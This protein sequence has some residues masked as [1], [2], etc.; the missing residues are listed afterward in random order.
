[1]GHACFVLHTQGV[2]LAT[3]PFAPSLGWSLPTLEMRIVTSSHDHP[4]HRWLQACPGAKA[5]VGPGEYEVAGVY[6]RG[7]KT[8]LSKKAGP[9]GRNTVF[10]IEVEG[11][12][13]AH[14]GDLG[15]VPASRLVEDIGGVHILLLPVG[16]VCTISPREAVETARLLGARLI[17]PMH[18]S[19]PGIAVSLQS[20]EPF[21]KEMGISAPA[22]QTRLQVNRLS[23]PNEPQVITLA[24]R[25]GPGA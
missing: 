22:Q 12:T 2:T 4:H 14:L 13:I 9:S 5:L 7:Y 25:A 19:L 21:L 11:L 24:P 1:M 8:P 6:I 18:Y 10:V 3:D 16:G 20:L 23:L 15:A 17:I